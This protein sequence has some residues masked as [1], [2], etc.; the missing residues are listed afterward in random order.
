M[1]LRSLTPVIIIILFLNFALIL[2]MAGTPTEPHDADAMWVEPSSITFTPANASVGQKFNVTVWLNMTTDVFCYQIALRYNRTHLKALRGGFTAGVKSQ[3]MEGHSTS[4]SGPT[5]DTSFLG[6]GS[7]LAFESCYGDDYIPEPQ[8]GSL[9]WIEFQILME[10]PEGETLTSKIDITTEYPANTFVWDPDLADISITT[11]DAR[12]T[13]ISPTGPPTQY[14]L[15]VTHSAGG[16]TNLTGT[17][18]Y[19]SGTVVYVQA[20]P[21]SG[22]EL[23]HWLLDDDDV[24][25]TNPYVIL[26]NEDH[27]LHAEFKVSTFP[28]PIGGPRICVDPPDI[29]DPMLLPSSTFAI[30]ITVANVTDLMVCEFNLSYNTTLL[31]CFSV[32]ILRVQ[33]QFPTPTIM[34]DDESGFIWIKLKYSTQITTESPIPIVKMEFHVEA[35]GATPL[36]LHDTQ[37]TDSE[38]SPI[39]H[40]AID[41]LFRNIKRDVTITNVVPERSY[42]YHG[43]TLRINVTAKNKGDFDETFDVYA[44]YD[45]NLIDSF[46]VED[47][48]PGN[49]TIITFTWNTT[50]AKPH[51]NYT[52]S[53][54][55]EAV[56][57]EI[58]TSDNTYTDGI[59]EVRLLGDLNN[60]GQVDGRDISE[61]TKA[62]ASYGP[63]FLYPGSPPHPRWNPNADLTN[64]N[65]IDGRDIVLIAKNFGKSSDP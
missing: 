32:T 7:V 46:T 17:H 18:Y 1:K 3:F 9:L 63:D 55:A 35:L 65:L 53:A 40:Q 13:F 15:T 33:G 51:S 39:T 49:E 52:I 48:P 5:I 6:P 22:Y 57:Y 16:T 41:G 58:D 44:Y 14:S 50:D 47:L 62:F 60:D 19:D 54:E 56:P 61:A 43:Q 10:P 26:M 23:D 20:M 36:D 12:Y 42:V 21:N 30:N 27:T 59:V 2:T 31:T 4:T 64:D 8:H 37:L 45:G 29:T 34:L 11:Y 24:G 38:G 28:P 25:K